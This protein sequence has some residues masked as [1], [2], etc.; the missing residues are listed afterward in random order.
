[1]LEYREMNRVFAWLK[2]ILTQPKTP[3]SEMDQ[4][5]QKFDQ[6]FPEPSLAQQREINTHQTIAQRRDRKK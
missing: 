3:L 2:K 5:L 1:M 6:R 4:L